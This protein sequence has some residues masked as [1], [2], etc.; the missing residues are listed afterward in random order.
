MMNQV[1]KPSAASPYSQS[2]PPNASL[3][4]ETQTYDSPFP[5]AAV[6]PPTKSDGLGVKEAAAFAANTNLEHDGKKRDHERFQTF[7]DHVNRA[8]LYI[9]WSICISIMLGVVTYTWHLL[10]PESCHYIPS[11]QLDE[12]K[13]IL[14][15]AILSSALTGYANKH[16][17]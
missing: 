16:L 15:A 5:K 4:T 7:R 10:T 9:F 17:K 13:T 3:S 12:L 6:P 8:T 14:G 2:T 11:S 1:D